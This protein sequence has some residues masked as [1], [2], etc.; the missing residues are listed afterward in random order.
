M[1]ILSTPILQNISTFD[2][3]YNYTIEFSY[4]DTQIQKKRLVV[5]NNVSSAKIYDETQ[6]G[7][8]LTFE[9]PGGSLSTGQFTAQIQVFDFD[10]NSSVLSSPV[11]FYCYS[12]PTLI[13]DEFKNVIH[14]G[15]LPLSLSYRQPEGDELKEFIYCLYDND[16]TTVSSSE[17]FYFPNN[18]SYTFYGLKN[19]QTYF[20]RCFGKTAHGMDTDTGFLRVDV[21]YVT[22]PNNM[23]LRLQNHQDEGY[24]SVSCNIIDIGYEIDNDSY[25][26]ENG[27]LTLTNN[28]LTYNSGF[29]LADEYSIFIKARKLPMGA[30]F[31][32]NTGEDEVTLS[33]AELGGDYYCQLSVNS[34]LDFYYRYA[35]LPK[36]QII[37]TYGNLILDN[38]GNAITMVNMSYEDKYTAVFELKRRNQL[39]SLKAYYEP[40]GLIII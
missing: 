34:A 9:L 5:V 26:I 18:M 15:N 2:P 14:S 28:R 40:N 36:A 11:L 38:N 10:G 7:M 6:H 19:E 24:I 22:Q 16:K 30:F 27:E 17:T 31:A 33:I 12:T 8:K 32:M 35:V 29:N 4:P 1:S 20:V 39:Y 23:I 3:S 25:T 21:D 13:F 37:D